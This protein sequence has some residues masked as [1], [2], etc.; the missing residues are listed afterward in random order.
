M[1]KGKKK[2]LIERYRIIVAKKLEMPPDDIDLI[3]ILTC[4]KRSQIDEKNII[5]F[6]PQ[7][8][9]EEDAICS[10][11]GASVIQ[12]ILDEESPFENIKEIL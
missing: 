4:F 8:K 3:S 10:F 7:N 11:V 6:R 5:V 2:K 1:D 12:K 9:K